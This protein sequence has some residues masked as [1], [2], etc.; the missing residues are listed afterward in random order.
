[1]CIEGATSNRG[2]LKMTCMDAAVR[3]RVE[4]SGYLVPCGVCN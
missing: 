4:L 2:N 3:S 1:M